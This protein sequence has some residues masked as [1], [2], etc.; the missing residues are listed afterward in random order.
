MPVSPVVGRVEKLGDVSVPLFDCIAHKRVSS[1]SHV[2][3]GPG[4][5]FVCDEPDLA[6]LGLDISFAK[7]FVS[8]ETSDFLVSKAGFDG[9]PF[10]GFD[11]VHLIPINTGVF[12]VQ[13]PSLGLES[14]ILHIVHK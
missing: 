1:L 11:E 12:D 7:G 4:L 3:V 10:D 6:N 2:D 5:G 13:S 14:N 8:E 9:I